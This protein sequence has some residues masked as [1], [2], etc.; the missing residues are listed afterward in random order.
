MRLDP[1]TIDWRPIN[2]G[3]MGGQSR[4][5]CSLDGAG[6][7]FQG[8]LS[9]A[10]GGGFASIRG[11]VVPTLDGVAGVRLEVT[12]DGRRYQIRL[13]ESEAPHDVAWRAVFDTTGTRQ[14]VVLTPANFQPVIRGRRIDGLSG[15]S[16]RRLQFI[17]FMLT[18]KE[19]GAFRLSIHEIAILPASDGDA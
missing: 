3:V 15:I 10:N 18:S 5:G 1:A 13:R 2:D 6:L 7:H 12:G 9:T 16:G 11:R 14:T 4:S 8:L 19:E 17:G